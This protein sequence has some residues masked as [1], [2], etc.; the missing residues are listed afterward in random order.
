MEKLNELLREY[1]QL[2]ENLVFDI[3]SLDYTVFEQQ[4]PFLN[5][6]A[7]V[8]NTGLTVFDM[9]KREH[10]YASYNLEEIFGYDMNQI[11]EVGNDYFNSKVHPDDLLILVKRGTDLLRYFITLPEEEVKKFK[12]QSEY[13]IQNH[14]GKY[15]RII[16]QHQ[17]LEMDNF[18][19]MWLSLSVVDVSPNQNNSDEVKG[20]LINIKTGE[21]QTISEQNQSTDL[22]KKLL[23]E[24]E[25]EILNLVKE[26]YLSK[27][28]SDNLSISVHTVNTH[29]QKILKKLSA[30]TSIEAIEF[31]GR[32]GLI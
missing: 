13:R 24:R 10:I 21:V 7:K 11:E 9:N 20:Q 26:G 23:T 15:I 4:I 27:E 2:L 3:E 19:N 30:N 17:V 6:M 25:A 22:S 16:E 14:Q 8:N 18:G 1:N 32:L 31:A 29:R 28:I 5:Q 12:Y